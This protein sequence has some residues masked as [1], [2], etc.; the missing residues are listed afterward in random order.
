MVEVKP[1]EKFLDELVVDIVEGVS[2]KTI[3]THDGQKTKSLVV[4]DVLGVEI[5]QDYVQRALESRLGVPDIPNGD[6]YVATPKNY[7]RYQKNDANF[8]TS[9]SDT[10][11]LGGFGEI[12]E[13]REILKM[14]LGDNK[15][16][17][18]E[19]TINVLFFNSISKTNFEEKNLPVGLRLIGTKAVKVENYGTISLYTYSTSKQLILSHPPNK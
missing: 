14:M 11:G 2:G 18:K 7:F 17:K 3:S 9:M 10:Y 12:E 4:L 8:S 13:L 6:L 1:G 5:I 15:R 16:E 19:T